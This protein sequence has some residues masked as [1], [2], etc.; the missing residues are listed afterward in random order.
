MHTPCLGEGPETLGES[1]N[2]MEKVKEEGSLI[3]RIQ[4]YAGACQSVL[5]HM[6]WLRGP[7]EREVQI[8]LAKGTSFSRKTQFLNKSAQRVN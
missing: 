1:G 8:C 6:G 2:H 4:K 3:M 5:L 7:R